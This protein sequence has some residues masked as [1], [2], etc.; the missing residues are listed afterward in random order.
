MQKNTSVS[1]PNSSDQCRKLLS[2][3]PKP[4]KQESTFLKQLSVL[5]YTVCI[6]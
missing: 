5:W 6:K 4:N 2:F 3:P 1:E